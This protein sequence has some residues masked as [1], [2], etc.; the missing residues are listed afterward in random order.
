MLHLQRI[1]RFPQSRKDSWDEHVMSQGTKVVL[2]S[3]VMLWY[4][5]SCT[6]S[7]V[8]WLFLAIHPYHPSLPAGLLDHILCPHTGNVSP[9][10]LADTGTSMWECHLWISAYFSSSAQLVL[11]VLLGWFVR[12]K[13]IG[14]PGAASRVCSKHHIGFLFSSYLA[15]LPFIPL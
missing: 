2:L 6:N 13:V 9:C 8:P 11:F 5:S 14:C 10:C 12:W 15:F 3:K 7:T 4:I 1:M